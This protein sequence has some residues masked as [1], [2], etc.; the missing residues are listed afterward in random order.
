MAGSLSFNEPKIPIVSNLT[1]ELL[2][3]EQATDP[4][5]W[6]RH[7]R[8]PVR[9]ADAVAT[10]QKQGASTYLEIGPD[11]VLLAMAR[12]CLEAEDQAAFVPS[13]R[14]GREE[15]DVIVTS[16]ALAQVS[17][18]KLDWGVFFKGT[19]ATRV[20]LPTYPF[21][22]KRYW[23]DSA[24]SGAGDLTAAGQAPADH[25]LLGATVELAGPD[26]EGLLLTG[27]LSLAT[28]PWLADH[29]V[30]GAVLL[31][32]TAFLELALRAGEQVGA[33]TV[34]E[35]T[36]QAPLIFSEAGAVAIQVSVSG[37]GEDGRR[38]IQVHSRP[39]GDGA[40][41]TLN[42]SGALSEQH[43]Q[44]A[45]PLTEWPPEGAESI[46]VDYLYD[47]LA[48]HGFEYGSAFQGLG[49]A[50][51][52]GERIYLEAS[53]PEEIAGDAPSFAVHPALLES[54]LQGI[55]FADGDFAAVGL[56]WS[57]HGVSLE[58]KGAGAL[59]ARISPA[60]SE[61]FSLLIADPTGAPLASIG[62]VT[63]RPLGPEQLQG[64]GRGAGGLL[65]LE[66]TEVPLAERD[67]APQEVKLL[68]CE[69]EVGATCAE[70]ARKAAQDILEA[71]QQWLAEEREEGSRLALITQAAMAT[72]EESPDPAAAAIW[73]LVRSAQAEHPGRFALI[74]TDGSEASEAALPAALALGAEEPQLALREGVALAPRLA[75]A[76]AGEEADAAPAIDPERTALITGATGG[77]GALVAR[78][79]AEHHGARHLLLVSRSG[80]AAERAEELRTELEGLGAEVTIA[81]CDVS[82]R[83]ALEELLDSV[84]SEHP[85]GTVIHC[86]GTIADGTVESLGPEQ[87]ER[88]FAPKAQGAWNLHELTAE[89]DLSAFVLF[90]S[91]AGTLGGPGQA[92]YAAA[93]VFLDALAGQRKAEGLPATAIAW[94]LWQRESGI[95]GGLGEADL[96]R[97]RRAGAEVLT[98]EQGLALF[99]AALG[100]QSA[101]AVALRLN[102][103]GLRTQAGAG[104]LPP[105]LSGLVRAPRRR[106]AGSLAA[107]LA[108]LPEARRESIVLD[109]L[110]DE[111]ALVLGHASAARVEPNRAFKEMGFD[112]LAAVE[113]RNRLNATAG[114]DLATTAIFDYPTPR[115]LAAYLL[116]EVSASGAATKAVLRAQASEEPIAICG[117]ACRYPGGVASPAELWRL[118]EEGHDGIAAFPADRG[119]D[120]ERIYHP[121]PEHPG[122]SYAREGGFLAEAAG[123]DSEF[124]GIAP[125]EALAMDPQQRLLLESCW[126]A[127][128][129]AGIDPAALQGEPAG[130]FAG[131]SHQ[132]YAALPGVSAPE[133]EGYAGTGMAGSVASG[134]I[135]Y[136]LGL[137]GPAITIDTACS[138]SLVAM[139][140]AA[141]ALRGGECTLALAGGATV[142]SSPALFIDFARQRGLAPDGRCKS[143]AEA[144]DGTGWAEGVGVLVLERLSEAK[145][146]GHPILAT[147]KGSAVNQDGASNG[148]TAPNG[149]SQ[150]R[151]IR[152]ALANANLTPKDIDAVEAH[153]TGTTLG[154]PIEAG[155]LLATYGQDRDEP[156]KLGSIKSNIGHTQAAAGVAGVIKMT[157]AMRRGVLPKT[158][159]VDAP[160]SHVDWEAGEIELLT[161][162]VPW[163]KDGPR[164]A[165]VSSFG[166]SGTNAHVILEE[167]PEPSPAEALTTQPLAGPIPLILSAKA[168]PA[169]AEAAERLAAHLTENPELDP[170]DVA[171]S[172]ATTRSAFEHRAVAL[173]ADREEL[174]A[175]L[176]ALP[177]VGRARDGKLAFLFT[178]QGSQRLGMGKELYESDPL[179]K[180]AFER[181]CEQLDTH[182]DTPLQEIV[183][184]KGKKA[185]AL[186][187]DTTYA[188]PALFAI[189]VALFE[190]MGKRGLDP[191]LLAGHSIGE[192]AAA[193]VAGVLDLPD[194]SKLV[195][196]RGRLMGALPKGG[197][198]AAIE[199]TEQE[200]AD[201]IDGSEADLAI[202]AVNGPTATVISG[203]EEAVEEIR[204]QWDVEGRRTKA[205]A[206]S[207]AF[208]S[209]LMEP[210]LE[211][212]GE[213]A[214]SLAFHEPKLP[215]VSNLTGELLD[216]EQATDP[217]Y[218]VRHAR[219]PV[220]FADAVATLQKQGAST[221][222]EIGPDPVLLAM[223]RECLEAEDQAAFVP[224]LREGREEADV[225]VTSIALAQVSGAK[226]D[227]GV[228]F[229][230]TGATRV[231]LPTYPFQRK[232]YWLD[233]AQ[234]GA[235]DLTAAGQAPAD[236][237][238]LGATVELAGPDE[239]GLLLTGRLSLA[240]HPWL[241]DHAV[242]GAVLLPGT[243][244]LEL[245]LRAGEQVG[246]QTVEEL[247]LQAPLIFSEAGAV[248]IQ[249]SVSGPGED[250]RREI[251][252]HS[253]PEDEGAEWGLNASGVLS[254]QS[255]PDP[256]PFDAWPPAGA[257]P[258]DIEHLYDR[259]AEAGLEYGPTF[260]GLTA[261]WR[262]DERIYAEVSLPGEQAREAGRFGLHPALLDAALHGSALAAIDGPGEVR[263]PFAWG[264]VTLAVQGAKELRVRIARQGESVSLRVA[265]GAGAPVA[266]IDS[267]VSRPIDPE[268][269]QSSVQKRQGLLGIEWAE[270]SLHELNAGPAD[271]EVLRFVT[272]EG[273][274]AA[275]AART[276]AE[277]ALE[278]IQTWLA[279]ES[280]A[281]SRL[282][283]ITHRAMATGAESPDPTA[284]A[285]WGLV[286]SAQAEHPGRFALIDTDGSEAS[287]AALPAALA[288]GAEE[289]QLALRE[290][291]ALAPRIAPAKAGEGT[292]TPAIDPERTTLITGATGGLGV[293]IAR[294]L[295]EHHDARHLL[296]VSR[297][298]PEA[299]G[300]GEL[301]AELEDLGAEL[302][303]AAC[304]VSDREALEDLLRAVPTEHPL[305]AVVHCAGAIADGTVKTLGPEQ[306][307]RVFAPKADGA[308]NLHELTA[309]AGLSAFV[310]FSAGAG[311]LGAPGQANYAA[312]NVFLDALAQMRRAEGLPATSI[313]WGLWERESGISGGLGEADLARLRRAGADVLSDAQGLALF[314]AA[315]AADRP[316]ALAIPLNLPGLGAIA[317]AGALPPIFSGL[318]R[319]PRRGSADS[320]ALAAKLAAL[321]EA[322]HE[323][324][325]LELVRGEV[326]AVLGHASAG[327]I[328]P[329]RAFLDLGFDSLAAVELRNH[330]SAV[331]GLRLAATVVFDY[332]NAR[333]LAEH[334]LAEASASGAATTAVLRAQA[335]EEPIAIVGMACRYPGGVSSPQE[336]WRLVAQGREGIGDF[337]G[338]R[339]WDLERLYD[340][341]PD[342][343][344][345]SYAREGGFLD[346]AAE[347]DPEFFSISP[348][349][350]LT[351]DPQQRLLLES[352]WEALEDAGIDPAS[353]RKSQTGVF[354]G[355]M[356]QDYGPAPGMTA[357]IVSG[358][359]AYTLGLE[360]PAITVDT[361][362]SS[363]LVALHLAAQALRG[364]ECDLALA[365]GVT[366]LSTP[367]VFVEF[368]RQRG[369]APDG[370]SKSFADAA[371]GVAWSEGVG[372][373]VLERLSQ[374]QRSGRPILALLKGSAVNQ[375]GAS[376][377]LTA[378]NG[379][380]QERVIRQALANARLEAKDVDVVEGH[381]TGT[382]LGDPIEAGAL[383]ATYGQDREEPLK[384]GSIKSNIGHTQAAAG[385]AGVI[386]M[387]EAMRRGVLPK[388][389]HV[390][391]PSTKVDWEAGEIELL[392]EQTPWGKDGPRRAG[393]SSF[394]ISGTNAH[395]ILEEAPG[396]EAVED[397]TRPLP[398]PIPLVLS[399]KAEPALAE[400][401]ERLAS[402]L[403]E[404]PDLDPTNLAYSLATTRSAF[405]HRA[406]A[407]GSDR[408]ELLAA[409][410]GGEADPNLLT[411]KATDGK[412]ALLFTGQGSQRLGMGRELHE[413]DPVFRDAFERVCEQL[414]PHLETPLQEIVFA[415]GKKAQA[416]LDDTTYA[417]PALF[418]IEVA[419]FEALSKRGL[420]ADLLTGHSIGEIA[421]A[422]VAGVLEL[423]DAAKLVAAR[424]RLMG[425]LPKGGAMAAIEATE[426]EV[427]GSIEGRQ[428][429][430][431]I[432]AVNGPNATVI[433][434][435]AEAVEEVRARWDAEGRRTKALA[436]SHAFHSP[437]MEPMLEEFAEVAGSLTFSEPRI[438]IV[439]NVS[440]ELLTA[441]HVT[442]PAYWVRHAREPVRFA[443]VVAT[444]AEQGAAIYLELGPDPVLCAMARECLGDEEGQATF[445]PTLREGREEAGTVS[446]AIAYAHAAGANLDWEAF[447]KGTGAKRVP[448]P[449]YPFQRRRYWLGSAG[450]AS[451]GAIGQSAADH[452]LLAAAIEDPDGEGLT[453][454]GRLSLATHPWLADHAVHGVVLLPGTAFLELALRAGE[455]VGAQ[456]VEELTLQAPLIF[457]EAGAAAIQ[458]SVSGP[459]EDGRR[460]IAI[461]SRADGSGKG[462]LGETSV[463]TRHAAGAL[464]DRG[465]QAPEPLDAWP[466]LGA[467]PVEVE[468]VYDRLAERG[469]EYGPSFQGLSAAWK[470]GD[471]VYAEV[472]LP[473]EQAPE[474][475]SFVVHPALFDAAFHA[476]I[477]LSLRA[478]G[479]GSDA[480]GLP[481]P[482]SWRGAHAASGGASSLRVRIDPAAAHEVVLMDEAGAP[483]LC[484]DS[485]LARPVSAEQ[486]DP[487]RRRRSLYRVEW[488]AAPER[489]ANG[490]SPRYAVLGE[491]DLGGAKAERYNDLAAL[492]A[493][494]DAG[495]EAPEQAVAA[496]SPANG[497]VPPEAAQATAEVALA[498]LQVW[499]AEERLAGSRLALVSEGAVA[500]TP[501]EA[502]D[503]VTAPV[504]GLVR[505]AISE[506]PGR[507][508]LI[509]TDGGEA[510]AAALGAALALG[511]EEPQL[512]LRDGIALVPRLARAGTDERVET[513]IRPIDPERT[514][515][516][517]GGL[518][519]L[520]ALAA[521]HLVES[522]GARRLLLVSRSGQGAAGAGELRTE[523][524]QLGAEVTIAAC[525]VADRAAL[526]ELFAAIPAEHPLGAVVHSAGALD[527]GVLGAMD[528]ERLRRMMRPKAD[529]AWHLHELSA[530]HDL[531]HFL[532]F[533]SAAGLLGGAAQ[534]NY[535]AANGFLDALAAL[536][537]AQGLPATSL[538][539]GLWDRQSN[540][541]GE[542]DGD[543]EQLARMATQIRRRLGFAP[544]APAQGLELLDAACD[545]AEPLLAPVRFDAAALR[546]RAEQ[547]A[548]PPILRSVVRAPARRDAQRGSLARRLAATPEAEH[549][550]VVVELVR[551]HAAAVLGHASARE[552]EPGRAF[553]E[554]GFDSL[555]A[556]ELRNRLAAATGLQLTP[557]LV[558]DYPST[559][560]LA[561]HLLVEVGSGGSGGAD[562]GEVAF[563][564]ALARVPLSRLRDA[565]L[566]E[567]LREVLQL[568]GREAHSVE[569]RLIEEIDAMDIDDLIEQTLERQAAEPGG[570]EPR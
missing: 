113:L 12:E 449:T 369:L 47:L 240:T 396:A 167:A 56:P 489:V 505:S 534:A 331:T 389:L 482:F 324:H 242:H 237:P 371:D 492:V 335:S 287:E 159:H 542:L 440:G 99:D 273:V 228:F 299:E 545:L 381:G 347:F 467:E 556:V 76:K 119:W 213:V 126:Q 117:M 188:Q 50:W 491:L 560:S 41:W 293:I 360:G 232:R 423:P 401:A 100:T 414:D 536:R 74:D 223:A 102:P 464:S 452:P 363:S 367:G 259:L 435:A 184:A 308:W 316:L 80:S 54:V 443:D 520:G 286:R 136:A 334:L 148:L 108:T 295:A 325:V 269:L 185:Q 103:T 496:I 44:L 300:A 32:G 398:G 49:A 61:G 315:L 528:P 359:V 138:S 343:P 75:R 7:A 488:Q 400:A 294:H 312:A 86:A 79:L 533:S 512:A 87:V 170:T 3:P 353:L 555:G 444:L 498:L 145:R 194:A 10:L 425:V 257:E 271:V 43:V 567:P 124:F 281:G 67:E 253:R 508:A 537:R 177:M 98:D 539:W 60:E 260:Q 285:I 429:E 291:A 65:G 161:E 433:S 413:S 471:R 356:Y 78:H 267:L 174:L 164:R 454:T 115:R 506:H 263:L 445:V 406:V 183:F 15:A 319:R 92:N 162:Q 527:D 40:E 93:N 519:G 241:A 354:A 192:I 101:Q 483:V 450:T 501:A 322:E 391:A 430:L 394:G 224:S 201:S 270:I 169:L 338:D 197:A 45:E 426:G 243:A 179:F 64:P 146:N 504:W 553:Q 521:R 218:W 548:L 535:A 448:L 120:L 427:A 352:C 251:Q 522:K 339:G 412:L 46:E 133:L 408:E 275:E 436:V 4:A 153:G 405:E 462:E 311:T 226:L 568:D 66:W 42:A 418:A 327:E 2:D 465:A 85:L 222:L 94:G 431:A 152:Q 384:L 543:A 457:S 563:R 233:S 516:I 473:E 314:D 368:S 547:G 530:E 428:A 9:F 399:A 8:E 375:D 51:K 307:K 340:P 144:A 472:A 140:L 151:V 306:V 160:S 238:L 142:I 494:I 268:Q 424:G 320:G 302:R 212:F 507:F 109:L 282:A 310:L 128:E 214:G 333:A 205:L 33:Q 402:H 127:L 134:R 474:A 284:A 298:G 95:S 328:E 304:D 437:L 186:L 229:K 221:Y 495:A 84:P 63:S 180:E 392:T 139:H 235:G 234:S 390:D 558:F 207:H 411:A 513:T 193:H 485:L 225:I 351:M 90:S 447:F 370:R 416:L 552:V 206:V 14:E 35:L 531:S 39:E 83:G 524:E 478:G 569:S 385:V 175:S 36:L 58:A 378:P 432:A 404:N 407:L 463:W 254:N 277:S 195:T 116:G 469:F 172:L 227:W 481:L 480:G 249:V 562:A 156:L 441:E 137:E 439:S 261:A 110:R 570:G 248:A 420:T 88:V 122:T 239:E 6:V 468:Y 272:K 28:H 200:V 373:L 510:S 309:G 470:D 258:L 515:L 559:L 216:P 71:V 487:A 112:S 19:G 397:S 25:P 158:L 376:N 290:G 245:A 415:E 210:M 244:F 111:V 366:V 289:P 305:G 157:E 219:E 303:I 250:G 190:A 388:T 318:V 247:T 231:P 256:E 217:A 211:E 22:R 48:E 178:G 382:T 72:A 517:T 38:E 313:A 395:V 329:A 18:A 280:K 301:Q 77:L 129:D 220:R 453:L 364:G 165:G 131:L 105:I 499:A 511:A 155:A 358:R 1:G 509:D 422:H 171:Y 274:P 490:A 262:Q 288:L 296:L 341:D 96:A 149:P 484:L 374:A 150:E 451:A 355:V 417:Q 52:E 37:P 276:V 279:D 458:V 13:L 526:E 130:V 421:A 53:L 317:A 403:T 410:A 361:A 125:R 442:D 118:L 132:G 477:D 26:E 379:P 561:G 265:D 266:T 497:V 70:A 523:L 215:V 357:S 297:S 176:A 344:G 68:H 16:I 89:L 345:T 564:E 349:E 23:L 252:V 236:H 540:L 348:R 337:P 278:A 557:T 166:I 81:A 554:M 121:D 34:E 383:L 549:E 163:E 565:G 330:L 283:L 204:A 456:T 29:A 538:A 500:A 350:A 479:D 123:F 73:G 342:R 377:G 202:A 460:E 459:G 292:D 336:L 551:S 187:D 541:A 91:V 82:D 182:L 255:A 514:V 143:F 246:A 386:K 168:E 529:A 104:T 502:P 181:A 55:G 446:T 323:D 114:L 372:V 332:P 466:P 476:G 59:R 365:G 493:A 5:Y 106:A 393:V 566:I 208:H 546:A 97:I 326:A 230:G 20:P 196:A 21:Q 154:D 199:A 17:G 321:S 409:L 27:R 518:S 544:M 475:A 191:D 550:G 455:E 147:I 31:P 173:G 486:L 24:Q 189:E 11:P 525:D 264:G 57:W 380:S 362:C 62:K 69:T 135:A 209:P 434:G 532:L 503:L 438:P 107:R 419:L 346:G 198:M 461:H 203:A 30:H 141:Q 387:T